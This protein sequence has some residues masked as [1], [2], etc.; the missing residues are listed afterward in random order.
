MRWQHACKNL[1]ACQLACTSTDGRHVQHNACGVPSP[2]CAVAK[3]VAFDMC[4]FL[5]QDARA[6]GKGM[7]G[8]LAG[9]LNVE[10]E[11]DRLR[12]A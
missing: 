10:R 3:G 4:D 11:C 5:E 8:L 9:D 2:E 1:L 6:H 7:L 12:M